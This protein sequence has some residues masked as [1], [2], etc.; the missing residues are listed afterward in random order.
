MQASKRGT[1]IKLILSSRSRE[2]LESVKKQLSESIPADDIAIVPLDLDKTES[3]EV[4]FAFEC[5]GRIDIL[6]NNAG[7]SQR[8]LARHTDVSVSERLSRID[9]IGQVA[10]AQKYVSKLIETGKKG[11]IVN[12]SSV[13]GKLPVPFRSSYCAA[14][15]ALNAYSNVLRLELELEKLPISV[16][17]ISPGG[18]ATDVSR[19]ALDCNG[20][21]FG[22]AD[23]VTKTGMAVE[24]C[25]AEMLTAI[26][27]KIDDVCICSNRENLAV[28]LFGLLPLKAATMV[29]KPQYRKYLNS[30]LDQVKKKSK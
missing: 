29:M 7:I 27:N 19:N 11:H 2:T 10:L 6:V 18:V 5:F 21:S 24:E 23:E 26:S 8:S 9:Y 4:D 25:V 3:L 30:T 20:K 28:K 14:K 16:S 22:E 17:T 15:A 13:A 12:V 1:K